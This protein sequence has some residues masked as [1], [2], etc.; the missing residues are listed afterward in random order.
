VNVAAPAAD[1]HPML[2]YARLGALRD[3][4]LARGT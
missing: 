3:A 1:A 4:E 2:A